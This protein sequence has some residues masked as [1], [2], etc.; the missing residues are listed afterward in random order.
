[1]SRKYSGQWQW[2]EGNIQAGVQK[3]IQK[4]RQK[5]FGGGGRKN[6][7]DGGEQKNIQ[8]DSHSHSKNNNLVHANIIS[9]CTWCMRILYLSPIFAKTYPNLITYHSF[10]D[11][12]SQNVLSQHYGTS[13]Q[14]RTQGI[15]S[16]NSVICE[17]MQHNPY[18]V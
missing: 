2:G 10:T 13:E 14:G 15:T 7:S 5:A 3:N 1:M 11:D 6:Y 16:W 17:Y 18:V 4:S 9:Q 12:D 8:G